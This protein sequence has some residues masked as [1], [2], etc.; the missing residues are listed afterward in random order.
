MR[1]RPSAVPSLDPVPAS[2][3]EAFLER[4]QVALDAERA[5]AVAVAAEPETLARSPDAA[6]KQAEPQQARSRREAEAAA[7][8]ARAPAPALGTAQPAGLR[9]R[10]A[11]QPLGR[12]SAPISAA[13]GRSSTRIPLNTQVDLSSDSNVFTGFSTNLSEG[14]LFVATVNLLP[15]GTPVDLTFTL[16]GNAK[17][18]VRGEVRWTRELDDRTPEVFPGVGVRFVELS[19]EAAKALH[20]FIASREPLFY[21]D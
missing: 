4:E 7:A 9:G 20:R 5:V 11:A 13:P 14:G 10:S 12:L 2:A 18:S 19:P 8:S 1:L 3:D 17:V 6:R 15:V 21:P 16:P